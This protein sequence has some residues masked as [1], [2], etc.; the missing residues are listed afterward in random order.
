MFTSILFCFFYLCIV[1]RYSVTLSYDGSGFSGWQ[2]QP[3]AVSVQEALERALSLALREPVSVTGAGRTDAGVNA[4]GYVAHF[5]ASQ[6]FREEELSCK[7]N[8]ILP[9][10]VIIHEVKIVP[11]DFHARFDAR[12]RRYNYFIHRRKDPFAGKYSYLYTY[13]LDV[14]A[15][16]MAC[17][18]LL[19]EHD[20]SCFEKSGGN[21]K[22]SICT[23]SEA[24]WKP[25]TPAHAGIMEYPCKDGDYLVFTVSAN[26]FLR[27]MVRAIV[28]T[29]LDIG[30]GR[31]PVSHM[32]EVLTSGNRSAAGESVP[33]HALFLSKVEY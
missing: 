15:M 3:N 18:Y 1:M 14:D 21:S 33:G 26:R 2:I 8:A 7:L 22:T 11:E 6:P 27:N 5:D 28:G 16:N 23:I 19:G 25:Y 31:Y 9:V 12:L 30:R 32:Q 4:I 24:F 20:F 13:P 29:L 10:S 17:Q